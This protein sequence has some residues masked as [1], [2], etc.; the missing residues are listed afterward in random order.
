MVVLDPILHPT[1]DTQPLTGRAATGDLKVTV[2]ERPVVTLPTPA[3]RF[4]L[5]PEQATF[6]KAE[7][8]INDD[9]KLRTH[10]LEVREEAY[11]VSDAMFRVHPR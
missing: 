1:M 4:G 5:S 3:T 11:K 10:I 8:G 9:N 2:V 7:T 6:F